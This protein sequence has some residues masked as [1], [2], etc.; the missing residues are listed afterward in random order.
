MTSWLKWPSEVYDI[1]GVFDGSII[2]HGWDGYP[3]TIYTSTFAGPL[4]ATSNPAETEGTE[5]QSI[6][7]TKDEGRSW[8]KL[9][10][11]AQGN[12]V[13]CAYLLHCQ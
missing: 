1:R 10:F 7:F 5:T 8:L 6:A 9:K 2:K 13:I 12:P 4:G 3:T 11:G